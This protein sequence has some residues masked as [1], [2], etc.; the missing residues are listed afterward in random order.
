MKIMHICIRVCRVGEL[1]TGFLA[2]AIPQINPGA[3]EAAPLFFS[4]KIM[5]RLTCSLSLPTLCYV[6]MQKSFSINFPVN[7]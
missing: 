2:T 1:L 3:A 4:S 7:N 6:A 5:N